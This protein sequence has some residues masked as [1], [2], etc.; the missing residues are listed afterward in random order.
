MRV[1]IKSGDEWI[2]VQTLKTVQFVDSALPM[3]CVAHD[4]ST[5]GWQ[6][7]ADSN[8]KIAT[9]RLDGEEGRYGIEFDDC[10]IMEPDSI[11]YNWLSIGKALQIPVG[12]RFSAA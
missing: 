5:R 3:F 8:M 9:L 1:E 4:P 6:A 10:P 2:P 11:T 12:S 7:L